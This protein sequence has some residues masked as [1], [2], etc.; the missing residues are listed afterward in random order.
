MELAGRNAWALRASI[1]FIKNI[2]EFESL[3]C[4]VAGLRFVVQLSF[5]DAVKPAS[6]NQP[7]RLTFDFQNNVNCLSFL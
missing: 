4:P 2:R 1:L 6:V 7:A 3:S 5:K